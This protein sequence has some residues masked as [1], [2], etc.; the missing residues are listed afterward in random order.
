M[1]LIESIHY[2]LSL[3]LKV[4]QHLTFLVRQEI[5]RTFDLANPILVINSSH[6]GASV[7]SAGRA[8]CKS[9][10]LSCFRLSKS[11]KTKASIKQ[12]RQFDLLQSL[13]LVPI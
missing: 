5:T 8:R 9:N 3:V 7:G 1:I 13:Q 4:I 2:D 11:E 6:S 10:T 12:P